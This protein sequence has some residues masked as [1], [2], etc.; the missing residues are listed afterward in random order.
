MNTR[1]CERGYGFGYGRTRENAPR[2]GG[3]SNTRRGVRTAVG[4]G[5]Y[6]FSLKGRGGPE[7]AR[8]K[9]FSGT[10]RAPHD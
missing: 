1:V 9:K 7:G 5:G 3:G 6:N 10:K 2:R 8:F 4:L